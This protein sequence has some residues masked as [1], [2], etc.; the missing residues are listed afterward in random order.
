[1]SVLEYRQYLSV[2]RGPSCV[3]AWCEQPPPRTPKPTPA[4]LPLSPPLKML[5]CPVFSWPVFRSYIPPTRASSESVGR[6][7]LHLLSLSF[8]FPLHNHSSFFP[9]F[10]PSYSSQFLSL[11][12]PSLLMRV[13][14]LL[15]SQ[16][17]GLHLLFFSLCIFITIPPFLFSSLQKPVFS[18]VAIV[19]F[20]FLSPFPP[21]L[22]HFHYLPCFPSFLLSF[23][24]FISFLSPFPK[25]HKNLSFPLLFL[26]K[27]HLLSLPFATFSS[28]SSSSRGAGVEGAARRAAV[29]V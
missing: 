15:V 14:F 20:I 2:P 7:G 25:H 13:C 29:Y 5:Y 9:P 16:Y 23:Y 3:V 21:F 11:F 1:M 19:A 12:P 26:P 6:L 4:A 17:R 24:A 18:S 22:V 27:S 28:A 8:L 10:F